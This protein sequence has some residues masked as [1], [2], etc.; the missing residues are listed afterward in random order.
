MI[1]DIPSRMESHSLQPMC[2]L[3]VTRVLHRL[4]ARATQG[5]K[6][7]DDDVAVFIVLAVVCFAVPLHGQFYSGLYFIWHWIR[8]HNEQ[9]IVL[10][11]LSLAVATY[12]LF[13]S[14]SQSVGEAAALHRIEWS[15]RLS[16]EIA[17]VD[18]ESQNFFK[19]NK[20]NIGLVILSAKPCVIENGGNGPAFDVGL[21]LIYKGRV[22]TERFP[23]IQGRE[24]VRN[25]PPNVTFGVV[26]RGGELEY[27]DLGGNIYFVLDWR[28]S[29]NE[30]LLRHY[31][32]KNDLLPFLP[33][34]I[35]IS[36]SQ[37]PWS[38]TLE[39]EYTT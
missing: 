21:H 26:S 8:E 7:L 18:I 28:N 32:F 38:S 34:L 16:L 14:T 30:R 11:T 36:E 23:T 10:G 3:M 27:S 31:A 2:R 4:I 12:L 39:S 20:N 35:E 9:L 5:L 22:S 24:V 1:P 19:E 6:T 15:S 25:D 33:E 29:Y 13:R 37:S 17:D